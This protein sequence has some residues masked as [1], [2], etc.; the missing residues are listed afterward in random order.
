MI[1]FLL[2][3]VGTQ[4]ICR[5][6]QYQNPD[7]DTSDTP[8]PHWRRGEGW[9]T[10]NTLARAKLKNK[11]SPCWVQLPG[12]TYI[13]RTFCIYHAI[14]NTLR[15]QNSITARGVMKHTPAAPGVIR[16]IEI[17]YY[18]APS[19]RRAP[20]ILGPCHLVRVV[21][22]ASTEG[23]PVENMIRSFKPLVYN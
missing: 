13:R 17:R 22:D 15:R 19:G 12:N 11:K 1:A 10:E 21:G 4:R 6:L 14:E 3:S 2:P 7:R 23:V 9:P 8:L 20:R 5:P 16:D 18:T